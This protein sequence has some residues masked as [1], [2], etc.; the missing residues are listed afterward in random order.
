MNQIIEINTKIQKLIDVR[1]NLSLL[2]KIKAIGI[3]DAQFNIPKDVQMSSLYFIFT[4]VKST[5]E[6]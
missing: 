2:L 5:T 1:T 4:L 6:P 3:S